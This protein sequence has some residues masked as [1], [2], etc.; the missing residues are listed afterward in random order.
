MAFNPDFLAVVENSLPTSTRILVGCMSGK[1]SEMACTLMERNGYTDLSNVHGGF[2]GLKDPMGRV[3]QTGWAA[4]GL[5]VSTET[6]EGVSY[7]SLRK[8]ALGE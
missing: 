7:A 5:P 4:L 2:G 8:R 3:I 1:R 6:G